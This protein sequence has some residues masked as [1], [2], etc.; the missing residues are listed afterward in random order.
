[1]MAQ[2]EQKQEG[3]FFTDSI[4]ELVDKHGGSR[5]SEESKTQANVR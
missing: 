1:M 3:N 5:H 4:D 2:E